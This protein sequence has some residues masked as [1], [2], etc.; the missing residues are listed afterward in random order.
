MVLVKSDN[1]MQKNESKPLFLTYCKKNNS[2][3]IDT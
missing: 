3:W 1:H 2:K